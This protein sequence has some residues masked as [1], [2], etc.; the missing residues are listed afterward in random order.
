MEYGLVAE[1]VAQVDPNLAIRDGKGQIESV[2][3]AAV[4]ATSLNEFLKEHRT[5][6]ELKST[7][8]TTPGLSPV[9]VQRNMYVAIFFNFQFNN[10][11]CKGKPFVFDSGAL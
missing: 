10:A 6:Q 7:V 5:V 4:N 8:T 3:H 2:C 11:A 1:E 9:A